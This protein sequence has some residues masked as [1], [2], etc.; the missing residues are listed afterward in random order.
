LR[1][2]PDVTETNSP[3]QEDPRLDLPRIFLDKTTRS[4][5]EHI[6]EMR[7]ELIFNLNEVGMSD[8]K[9]RKETKVIIPKTIDDQMAHHCTSRIVKHISI[10]TWT[11]ARE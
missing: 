7:A 2:R 5:R 10:A 1:E 9:D 11:T 4:Y 8:W 3:P 6:Q